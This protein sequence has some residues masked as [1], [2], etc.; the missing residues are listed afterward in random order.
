ML[1]AV[2]LVRGHPTV[3]G[4]HPARGLERQL[5]VE[6]RPADAVK[7][8]EDAVASC[9]EG[10]AEASREVVAVQ[11]PADLPAATAVQAGVPVPEVA[12]EEELP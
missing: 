4:K 12:V 1:R 3:S 10:A 11:K 2:R 8:P 5:V 9:R 6:A 7:L